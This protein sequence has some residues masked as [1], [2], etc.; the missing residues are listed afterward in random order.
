[1]HMINKHKKFYMNKIDGQQRQRL[2]KRTK[3]NL[4]AEE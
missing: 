3:Q 4:K 2:F 1:M